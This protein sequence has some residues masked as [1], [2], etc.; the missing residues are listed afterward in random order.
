MCD[1]RMPI[2]YCLSLKIVMERHHLMPFNSH[3]STE[4]HRD[5]SGSTRFSAALAFVTVPPVGAPLRRDMIR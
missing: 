1:G 5:Q 4:T 2:A 3:L